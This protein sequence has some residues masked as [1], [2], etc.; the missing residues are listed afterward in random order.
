MRDRRPPHWFAVRLVRVLG[1]QAPVHSLL[2][3]VHGD[4]YE[5]LVEL[6]RL[7]PLAPAPGGAERQPLLLDARGSQPVDGVIEA[8]ARLDVEGRQRAMAFR[9][10]LGRNRKWQCTALE[11]DPALMPD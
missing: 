11:L 7:A 10:E 2:G 4:C 9:L 3:H 1:A 5:R 6:A 8:F